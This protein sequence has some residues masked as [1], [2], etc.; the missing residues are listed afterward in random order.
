MAFRI[1]GI[2]VAPSVNNGYI[3]PASKTTLPGFVLFPMVT[4]LF[5]ILGLLNND[6][7]FTPISVL[8]LVAINPVM[9]PANSNVTLECTP[10]LLPSS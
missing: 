10:T 7:P 9:S 8:P 1:A 2:A 5:A 6:S 4:I 3:S